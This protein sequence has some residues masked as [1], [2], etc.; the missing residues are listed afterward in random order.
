MCHIIEAEDLYLL[1]LIESYYLNIFQSIWQLPNTMYLISNIFLLWNTQYLCRY[2]SHNIVW[3]SH[4]HRFHFLSLK[5]HR[6]RFADSFHPPS[7]AHKQSHTST[8]YFINIFPRHRRHTVN[9]VFIALFSLF[10]LRE[11]ENQI[12]FNRLNTH[13]WMRDSILSLRIAAWKTGRLA[14]E[15]LLTL[16]WLRDTFLFSPF[17]CCDASGCGCCCW[18]K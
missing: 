5:S 15:T 14:R 8:C 2:N 1:N 9:I 6:K 10:T 17:W 13:R 16:D 18:L 3:D 11:R 4:S 12:N 7:R